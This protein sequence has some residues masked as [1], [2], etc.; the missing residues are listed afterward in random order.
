MTA[1]AVAAEPAG[2]V[3][4]SS[5]IGRDRPS[6]CKN[7]KKIGARKIARSERALCHFLDAGN[8]PYQLKLR[9]CVLTQPRPEADCRGTATARCV[10]YLFG[11]V[12]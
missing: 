9:V 2:P 8:S 7:A 6:L 1:W 4:P 12:C 5:T 11:S 10:P 3:M